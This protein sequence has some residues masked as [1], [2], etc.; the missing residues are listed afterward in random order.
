MMVLQFIAGMIS[1]IGFAF[2]FNCPKKAICQASVAGGLGWIAY[3]FCL[4][5]L[6]VNTVVATLIGTL[7]LSTSSSKSAKSIF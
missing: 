4:E 2:L 7:V 1:C 6:A 5:Y 3:A